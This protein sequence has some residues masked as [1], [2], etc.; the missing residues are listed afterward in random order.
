[1]AFPAF[2]IDWDLSNAPGQELK[3]R[4]ALFVA[5]KEGHRSKALLSYLV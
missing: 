2:L 5:L 1:M 4:L 3:R